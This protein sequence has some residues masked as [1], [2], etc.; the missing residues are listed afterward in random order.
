MTQ[1]SPAATGKDKP[2]SRVFR[3]RPVTI[4]EGH[5]ATTFEIFFD[6]VFVFALTRITELMAQAPT[7]AVLAQGL[8]LILW[9]WYA[10]TCYAWLGNR[11]R[12]D[13]GLVR[14]GMTVAMA[15]IFLAALVIP[16]AWR[17]GDGTQGAPLTL[18]LAYIVVRALHLA[19]W[20]YS[21]ANDPLTR[22]QVRRFA[23]PTALA[24]V[25]LILGAVVG[26]T[27]QALLWG[28]AFVVDYGGGRIA[29]S[30]VVGEV[31]SANHF[32]ERHSLVLIIALG[33]SLISVGAG[34]GSA[35]TH[36][37][38]MVAA[39]LGFAAAV[40]LWWLY[41]ANAAPAAGRQLAEAD[42]RHRQQMASDAYALAHLPL[43]A[44]V[45]Y[46]A[47][48][49]HEVVAH[50][51]HAGTGN[52]G[53]E[54]LGWTSST[55]LYCGAA[56]YLIGRLL[57]LR[58][59]VGSTSPAQLVAIGAIVVLLPAGRVLPALAAL[60]LLGA[61]LIVLACYERLSRPTRAES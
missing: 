60:G 33:E 32:A 27:G 3:S 42:A 53:G 55:A 35:V 38:V 29:A 57:F 31:H 2:M 24:W 5:R 43:I 58:F 14:A 21:A 34:A 56:V 25:P 45:I 44:G 36:W 47:L 26:G 49:I 20:L 61:I 13:V 7:R 59:T 40:C 37:P 23:V 12:A 8:L 41:F 22:R 1:L 54:S 4:E 19:L 52:A 10:W 18:A 48:G 39:L 50:V 46:L 9:F 6:L 15:A 17:R 30:Y 28:V 51:A 11:T 16:E